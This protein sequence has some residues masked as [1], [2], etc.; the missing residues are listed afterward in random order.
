M[1]FG[2]AFVCLS[3]LSVFSAPCR[4]AD[5]PVATV[6][7]AGAFRLDGAAVS[8]TGTLFA[9]S[10]VEDPSGSCVI[11]SA[12]GGTVRLGAQSGGRVTAHG[13]ELAHGSVRLSGSSQLAIP[14]A[15]AVVQPNSAEATVAAEF[16]GGVWTVNVTS[17]AAQ[18]TGQ[19]DEI[20]L[21]LDTGA[22]AAFIP[23]ADQPAGV[24]LKVS[25]CLESEQDR[26]YLLP[27]HFSRR[28]ELLGDTVRKN[29]QQVSVVGALQPL[30]AAGPLS[31]V[32]RV[33]SEKK[34]AGKCA[35]AG[36]GTDLTELVGISAGIAVAEVAAGSTIAGAI[37]PGTPAQPASVP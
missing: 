27:A 8:N 26:W 2:A 30:P 20:Y 1:D 15:A 16:A 23:A 33:V 29:R 12:A 31:G 17:G 25:G 13:F 14:S 22:V 18:L 34:A 21:L 19:H 36:T 28:L 3:F 37:P 5:V 7:C 10:A 35:A 24:N 4:A 9:G 6:D 11:R 32:V